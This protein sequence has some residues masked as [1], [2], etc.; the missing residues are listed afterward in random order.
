MAESAANH[1][2]HLTVRSHDG[3]SSDRLFTVPLDAPVADAL[4][5]LGESEPTWLMVERTG[6]TVLPDD[7]IGLCDLRSGDTVRM[8][9]PAG[10]DAVA[11]RRLGASVEILTGPR[12][13]E[14]FTMEPG[15]LSIGRA[16]DNRFVIIDPG[17]SR[18]HGSLELQSNGSVTVHDHGST[19]GVIVEDSR[20]TGSQQVEP[21]D[22]ILVGQTWFVVRVAP[23]NELGM[24]TSDDSVLGAL[25]FVVV[26]PAAN[27]PHSESPPRV[28]FPTPPEAAKAGL[29]RTRKT[30]D[31]EQ[32]DAFRVDLEEIRSSIEMLQDIEVA[33]RR[34]EAP[35]VDDLKAGVL[36]SPPSVWRSTTERGLA[37]RIGL[38][39]L[40]SRL[41]FELPSGGDPVLRDEMSA[42]V[43]SYRRVDNA[44]VII[45]LAQHRL[46]RI[47]G[48]PDDAHGLA[49][50]L[51][52]QLAL[53]Y[54]P[55]DVSLIVAATG[56][57]SDGW[58]WMRW[59]P[60]SHLANNLG[61]TGFGPAVASDP[62]SARQL[63][64]ELADADLGRAVIVLDGH[65]AGAEAVQPYLSALAANQPDVSL[66]VVADDGAAPNEAV[67]G[68]ASTASVEIS[69]QF[70]T[71][72][73][74]GDAGTTSGS[75]DADSAVMAIACEAMSAA[76]ADQLARSLAPMVEP[77]VRGAPSASVGADNGT[78]AD[79]DAVMEVPVE[80]EASIVHDSGDVPA[81]WASPVAG[82][83]VA[84]E[85]VDESAV[86]LVE[87][88]GNDV[89]A[90]VNDVLGGDDEQEFGSGTERAAE[91]DAT[92]TSE[93][94][95]VLVGSLTGEV[96]LP[97]SVASSLPLVESTSS[98]EALEADSGSSPPTPP[99]PAVSPSRSGFFGGSPGV[100]PRASRRVHSA[101]PPQPAS[102]RR[103]TEQTVIAR[104]WENSEAT[105]DAV[106]ALGVDPNADN[107][108]VEFDVEEEHLLVIEGAGDGYLAQLVAGLAVTQSPFK[109]NLVLLDALGG[110]MLAICDRL[111]HTVASVIKPSPSATKSALAALAAELDRREALVATLG[112]DTMSD[113]RRLK[114]NSSVPHLVVIVSDPAGTV[115]TNG[116]AGADAGSVVTVEASRELAELARRGAKLGVCTIVGRAHNHSNP[117]ARDRDPF[118]A[119]SPTVVCFEGEDA[120]VSRPGSDTKPFVPSP[121]RM[122]ALNP[123]SLNRLVSVLADV[124][125]SSG[126]PEPVSLSL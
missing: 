30:P 40:V 10:E 109:A 7:V 5:A 3:H 110:R 8:V 66:L 61:N 93:S 42:V 4:E 89:G 41:E 52:T 121:P 48:A 108:T 21:G 56:V 71:L 58:Q 123:D 73:I 35:G 77:V 23:V 115:L 28:E 116:H 15:E 91:R 62:E 38:A 14:T 6:K 44:P 113:L 65:A 2:F 11:E 103:G 95:I 114:P 126:R 87:N 72:V 49:R 51:V 43:D 125:R 50:S 63:L 105:P 104:T 31:D 67:A 79:P 74:S 16:A 94:D 122:A 118:M 34:A 86:E 39:S 53:R 92:S 33:N 75:V 20:I 68:I 90:D 64:A 85:M 98:P 102:G 119:A 46:T 96:E 88:N 124:F 84:G 47:L 17:V 100:E 54:R 29:F 81:N 9:A 57:R 12:A 59:L 55:S 99:A 24:S 27:P 120:T 32:V 101:P 76:D 70:G 82:A 1:T 83:E 60:H 112:C 19:N 18:F 97:G 80:S 107:Q 37:A 111:P 69:D 45:D 106:L 117:M 36:E 25:N 13:G 78:I 26:P 22:R